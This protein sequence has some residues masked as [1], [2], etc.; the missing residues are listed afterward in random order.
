MSVAD[1][2]GITDAQEAAAVRLLQVALAGIAVYGVVISEPA[3]AINA[4]GSLA[5]TLLPMLL[6]VEED[7][8]IDPGIVLWLTIATTLHAIG[9]TGPYEHIWWWDHVTHALA[10]TIVA[11]VAYATL[12][13][14][15]RSREAIHVPE[16]YR[17][18]VLV[19][20]VLAAAVVWEVVEFSATQLSTLMGA[21]QSMLVV[22]GPWDIVGDILYSG[23]GGLVVVLWGRGYFHAL[24]R[25]LS[26][27]VFDG[28]RKRPPAN[29]D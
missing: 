2:L 9:I 27:A 13:A 8:R 25:K 22:F 16:P 14:I 12:D 18:I 11:G 5:V 1:R 17:S 23:L 29:R 26:R 7:V 21:Q 4:I 20:F 19:I 6:R 15:D 3:V 10:G 28:T 24:S